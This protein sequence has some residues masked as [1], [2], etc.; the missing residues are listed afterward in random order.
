MTK[1]QQ[2][3]I[4]LLAYLLLGSGYFLCRYGL[5]FLHGM[6]QWPF[7][8]FVVGLLFVAIYAVC[9]KSIAVLVTGAGYLLSFFL[10]V[11][12]QSDGVDPG[13]GSTN[14]LWIIWT[15]AYAAILFLAIPTDVIYPRWKM[16]NRNEN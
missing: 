8:L 2:I 5:L 4:Q 16:R 3:W 15:V 7:L 6:H 9:R 10:G 11:L 14:T 12:F 1:K 13:G